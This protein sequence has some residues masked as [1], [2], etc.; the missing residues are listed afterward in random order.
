MLLAVVNIRCNIHGAE[1]RNTDVTAG[2]FHFSLDRLCHADGGVLAGEVGRVD[3]HAS[4]QTGD[5]GSAHQVSGC[6]LCFHDGQHFVD[7]VHDAH[8]VHGHGPLPVTD[9]DGQDAAG[10]GDACVGKENVDLAKL[11]HGGLDGC[12]GF[13]IDGNI[14]HADQYFRIQAA[15]LFGDLVQSGLV[16]IDQRQLH[17]TFCRFFRKSVANAVGRTG[18]QCYFS[19]K[20]FHLSFLPLKKNQMVSQPPSTAIIWPVVKLDASDAR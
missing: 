16:N 1:H 17:P 3:G 20:F 14:G 15:K 12:L 10:G 5:R 4:P 7:I 6:L 2:A 11:L 13:F 8:G 9:G 18:D 19:V